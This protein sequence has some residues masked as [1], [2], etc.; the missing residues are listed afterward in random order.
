[1]IGIHKSA[2]ASGSSPVNPA[3]RD[4]ADRERPVVQ[5]KRLSHDRWIG[6]QSPLPERVAH[7]GDE[8]RSDGLVDFTIERTS[9]PDVSVRQREERRGHDFRVDLLPPVA[10]DKQQRA[11]AAERHD[12]GEDVRATAIVQVRG[13]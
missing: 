8:V 3:R 5:E 10:V 1:M 7:D 9:A 2:E 6:P 4:A 12:V 11:R 13:K